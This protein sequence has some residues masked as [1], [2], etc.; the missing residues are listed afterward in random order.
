MSEVSSYPDGAPSWVDLGTT[1]VEAARGFY[2]GL[3]GWDYEIGPAE[4]GH[5]TICR[6]R[7]RTVAGITACRRR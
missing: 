2:S 1:D 4:T 5:Y 7:G 6:L 3:F